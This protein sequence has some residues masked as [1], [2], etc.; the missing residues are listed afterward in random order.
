MDA[1]YIAVVLSHL[2]PYYF[3]NSASLEDLDQCSKGVK[4]SWEKI[5]TIANPI[6][7]IGG[8]SKG[9]QFPWDEKE[10]GKDNAMLSNASHSLEEILN[11]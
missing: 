9:I 8:D 1:F 7:G 3:W 2:D 5:R 6:R 11:R 4:D 10:T